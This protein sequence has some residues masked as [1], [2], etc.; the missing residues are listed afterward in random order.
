[1]AGFAPSINGRFSAVHRGPFPL[2]VCQAFPKSPR[3]L[4]TFVGRQFQQIREIARWHVGSSHAAG[5][6]TRTAFATRRVSPR[7][8]APLTV[9]PLVQRR[10]PDERLR[11]EGRETLER[12][13]LEAA[14]SRR[15]TARW[16]HHGP[17]RGSGPAPAAT[18][19]AQCQNEIS[20]P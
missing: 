10:L 16:P 2:L 11:S 17:V 3:E 5:R 20:P 8:A 13:R 7:P 12:L 15:W 19:R 14:R 18:R 6:D 4:R 9:P 1:M